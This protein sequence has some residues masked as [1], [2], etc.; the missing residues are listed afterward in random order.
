MRPFDVQVSII[1]PG[2]TRTAI[3]DEVILTA[4]LRDLWN[5]LSL[6][7]Q[8]EYGEEYLKAGKRLLTVK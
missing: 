7:R 3:L 4:R 2:A 8:K 6:E 5:R 1:E